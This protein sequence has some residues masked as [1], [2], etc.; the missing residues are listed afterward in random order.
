MLGVYV[1]TSNLYHTF[2]IESFH[3][4]FSVYTLVEYKIHIKE[5]Y[6]NSDQLYSTVNLIQGLSGQEKKQSR[7]QISSCIFITKTSSTSTYRLQQKHEN[8]Q[9]HSN[10]SRNSLCRSIATGRSIYQQVEQLSIH[11]HTCP[12]AIVF[13]YITVQ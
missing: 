4:M 9:V 13:K 11:N 2:Y 12:I 6:K 10:P 7:N 1:F 5:S 3:N 8:K